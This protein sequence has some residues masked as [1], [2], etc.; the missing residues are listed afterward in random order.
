MQPHDSGRHLEAASALA[1]GSVPD[2]TN[3]YQSANFE[4]RKTV[5]EGRIYDFRYDAAGSPMPV[6][7]PSGFTSRYSLLDC[8]AF[9]EFGQSV[10]LASP[11][12]L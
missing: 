12:R 3:H 5:I 6:P 9:D 8:F 11:C 1:C 10:P 4:V 2:D 7:T